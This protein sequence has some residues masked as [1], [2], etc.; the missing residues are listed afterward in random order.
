MWIFTLN[1]ILRNYN[2]SK[3]EPLEKSDHEYLLIKEHNWLLDL[4]VI[5]LCF[6]FKLIN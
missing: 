3:L 2:Y 1:V 4:L 6:F 5:Q